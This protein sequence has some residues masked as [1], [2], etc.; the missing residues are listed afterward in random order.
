[1]FAVKEFKLKHCQ[2]KLGGKLSKM[3]QLLDDGGEV[4]KS[5]GRG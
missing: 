1:M 4:P 5:Q 2:L 3:T